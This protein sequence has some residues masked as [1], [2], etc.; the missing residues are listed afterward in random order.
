MK[1]QTW[2]KKGAILVYVVLIMA[3]LIVFGVGMIF[4]ANHN[5]NTTANEVYAEQA[6]LTARSGLRSTMTLMEEDTAKT[7]AVASQL[8]TSGTLQAAT[9]ELTE[10]TSGKKLGTVSVQLSCVDAGA[11]TVLKLD[12]TGTY[13]GVSQ[14]VTGYV[15]N[16]A[17]EI[18]SPFM[19]LNEVNGQSNSNGKNEIVDFDGSTITKVKE[20]QQLPKHMGDTTSQTIDVT[21]LGSGYTKIDCSVAAGTDLS[22]YQSGANLNVYYW[23]SIKQRISSNSSIIVLYNTTGVKNISLYASISAT[24][25]YIIALAEPHSI[26][27]VPYPG[28]PSMNAWIIAPGSDVHVEKNN[29]STFYLNGGIICKNF[30]WENG[31]RWTVDGEGQDG[32]LNNSAFLNLYNMLAGGG[33][34]RSYEKP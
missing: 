34:V 25:Q 21:K 27:L 22:I 14:T 8:K 5:T 29:P 2:K 9:E 11:C 4:L 12:S 1:P 15:K 17:P 23:G 6:Y 31:S 18:T 28:S 3:L 19:I 13:Q 10:K 7:N 20:I 26:E 30:S 16:S 32:I 33:W 24:S